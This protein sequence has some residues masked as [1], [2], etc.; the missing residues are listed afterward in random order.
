MYE[1]IKQ[2]DNSVFIRNTDVKQC[3]TI[4]FA[5]AVRTGKTML[6][7]LR[8]V[9]N[10]DDSNLELLVACETVQEEIVKAY[11]KQIIFEYLDAEA[12]KFDPTR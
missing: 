8:Y 10:E 9:L 5:E 2:G 12:Y 4:V 6:E 11:K 1:E 7:V 3:E